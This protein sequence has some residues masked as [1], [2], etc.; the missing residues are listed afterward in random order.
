MLVRIRNE[1]GTETIFPF[2][3]PVLGLREATESLDPPGWDQC[4]PGG[5]LLC[6]RPA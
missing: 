2:N 4:R 3:I 6:E 1:G 5:V